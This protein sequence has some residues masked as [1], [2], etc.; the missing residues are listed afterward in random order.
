MFEGQPLNK[1]L[2]GL[3]L[4]Y[5][6]IELFSRDRGKREAK[7]AF[8]VGQGSQDLGF[9]NEANLLFDCRPCVTV[10][11]EV[12]DDDGTPTMGQF[13]FRD[14]RGRVYPARSK[15]LAPDFSFHDQVY[16][17]S[18]EHVL[19][20]PGRYRVMYTRGPEYEVLERD[21]DVP[22][23]KEHTE[24]FR[25]RAGSV[26]RRRDGIP[27]IITSTRP[28]VPITPLPLKAVSP[29]TSCG[30]SSARIWMWAACSRGGLAGTT[31]NSSSKGRSRRYPRR[32]TCYATMSRCRD[33]QVRT[34]ATWCLLRLKEDDYP[35]TKRIEDWPSWTLPILKWGKG[36][37][38]HRGLRT[39]RL[40]TVGA[41]NKSADVR[42]ATVRRHRRQRIHRRCYARCLRLHLGGRY[43]IRVGVE[44][45]VPHTRLRFYDAHQRRDRFSVHLRRS[46]RFGPRLCENAAR[47]KTGIRQLGC[48]RAR[49]KKLLLRWPYAS[50]RFRYQRSGRWRTR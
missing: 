29:P 43:A 16:R 10:K 42:H 1:K 3:K 9:R 20:P 8:D 37:G 46:R 11:L 23:A 22:A 5:R 27:A 34:L 2:S 35:G 38:G 24:R 49:R 30:T 50:V 48:W 47:R 4:E 15:R 7:L 32:K 19:L 31:R 18:G 28:V 21:I 44:H 13:V 39:Q 45:L 14:E 40:G 17:K 6:V 33:F 25:L 12:Q 36:A 41:G 26:S